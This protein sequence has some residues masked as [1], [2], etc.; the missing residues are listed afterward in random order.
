MVHDGNP[1]AHSERLFL[2]VS[3]VEERHPQAPVELAELGL[4]FA[5]QLE[6]QRTERLIEQHD[7]GLQDDRAGQGDPLPLAAR[8]LT[9]HPMCEDAWIQPDRL[10]SAS[11]PAGDVGRRNASALEAERDVAAHIQVR[12]QRVAL[13]HHPELPRIGPLLVDATAGDPDLAGVGILEPGQESKRG[14]LPAA[15]RAQQGEE[16]TALDRKRH[17]DKCRISAIALCDTHELEDRL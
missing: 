4:H 17:I 5:P 10:E 3:D 7:L 16:L 13:E 15:R 12:K 8:K 2:V 14:G 6:I 9:G 11:N 1:I